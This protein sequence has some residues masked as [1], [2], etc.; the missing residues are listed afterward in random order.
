MVLPRRVARHRIHSARLTS[1]QPALLLR[2]CLPVISVV[3]HYEKCRSTCV[4]LLSTGTL[5]P[6]T[7]IAIQTHKQFPFYRLLRLNRGGRYDQ[8]THSGKLAPAADQ[9]ER[10]RCRI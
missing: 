4:V 10:Y 7:G 3:V 9:E 5:S 2:A 6:P 8:L 1:R